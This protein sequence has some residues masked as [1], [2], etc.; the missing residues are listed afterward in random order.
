MQQTLKINHEPCRNCIIE[1][2]NGGCQYFVESA[3]GCRYKNLREI[4]T[5]Y[6]Q[7]I[8]SGDNK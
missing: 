7:I 4:N 1:D 6:A 8:K 2:R 5:Q 3:D